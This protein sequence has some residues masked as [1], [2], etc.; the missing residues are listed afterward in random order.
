MAR[1]RSVA[2][3]LA[4]LAFGWACGGSL[5][6]VG[7][8]CFEGDSSECEHAADLV[9]EPRDWTFLAELCRRGDT[10]TCMRLAFRA[11]RAGDYHAARTQYEA[12]CE[13]G[14][15]MA[16]RWLGYLVWSGALREDA[17]LSRHADWWRS[18]GQPT[19]TQNPEPMSAQ[20]GTDGGVIRGQLDRVVIQE[21]IRSGRKHVRECYVR[22]LMET[23]LETGEQ[24]EGRLE[25]HLVIDS[26]GAVSSVTVEEDDLGRPAVSRCVA[27]V[28]GAM[29]F[30]E[31]RNGGSVNV[32]YPFVFSV[33][34]EEPED[35]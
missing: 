19:T 15:R 31:P 11:E 17:S 34:P 18:L 27:A 13:Q 12:G 29:G 21:V 25:V 20:V 5:R 33:P 6:E 30:P 14:E 9:G 24:T 3:T 22:D 2:V 28:V 35:P 23:R 16:C 8:A 1:V 10:P 7:D 4:L 32:I 26:T